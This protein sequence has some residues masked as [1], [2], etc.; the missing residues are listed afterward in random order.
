MT[1]GYGIPLDRVLAG[2]NR[3]DSLLLAPT[4]DKLGELRPLPG[5][6]R[7]PLAAGN[8]SRAT[9]DDLAARGMSGKI[10]HKGVKGADPGRSALARRADQRLAQ[11][12]RPVAALLGT[13]RG[14]DRR[15][16][17]HR[18]CHHHGA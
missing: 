3:H 7:V 13:A 9:R 2:A 14:C 4:L 17:R 8:D 5:D 12:L 1:D 16:L 6:V 15:L 11:R 18:R 10:A